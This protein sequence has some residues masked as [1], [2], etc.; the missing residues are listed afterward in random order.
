MLLPLQLICRQCAIMANEKVRIQPGKHWPNLQAILAGRL[1]LEHTNKNAKT[2]CAACA[3][4][5]KGPP[6]HGSCTGRATCGG[7]VWQKPPRYR[8][9]HHLGRNAPGSLQRSASC[10][11][12]AR[13][14]SQYSFESNGDSADTAFTQKSGWLCPR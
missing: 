4:E 3:E 10:S 9:L 2:Y 6:A 14:Q 5:P 11:R 13:A 1:L 12:L 7:Y 8:R